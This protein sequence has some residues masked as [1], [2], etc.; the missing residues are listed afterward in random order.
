MNFCG[1]MQAHVGGTAEAL[2][3]GKFANGAVT[4]AYVMMLNHLIHD[5]GNPKKE[6]DAISGAATAGESQGLP[7][8]YEYK[9]RETI[10]NNGVDYLLYDNQC[11]KLMP[12]VQYLT[13][14]CH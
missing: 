13:Q 5:G 4:G 7:S 2:G 8:I 9:N 10:S 14:I 12:M 11:H 3:G 6:V 1:L